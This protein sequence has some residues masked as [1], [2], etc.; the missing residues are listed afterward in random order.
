MEAA[1][2]G[3]KW[4]PFASTPSCTDASG[5]SPTDAHPCG[6]PVDPLSGRRRCSEPYKFNIYIHR[7]LALSRSD[8]RSGLD[9]QT[10]M[11][12][13][14]GRRFKWLGIEEAGPI[15]WTG[16]PGHFLLFVVINSFCLFPPLTTHTQTPLTTVTPPLRKQLQLQLRTRSCGGC[17][18]LVALE[19]ND[20]GAVEPG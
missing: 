4:S 11:E 20:W 9:W 13:G 17:P 16:C 15:D 6:P 1:Q 5:P 18:R 19:P 8:S 12:R 14:E 7:N 2:G 10:V 3:K